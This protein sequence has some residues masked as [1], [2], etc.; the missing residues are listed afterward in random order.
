MENNWHKEYVVS[1]KCTHVPGNGRK[2]LRQYLNQCTKN[3]CLRLIILWQATSATTGIFPL[4]A[5]CGF[6]SIDWITFSNV[7]FR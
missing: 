6:F 1:I 5:Y 7:S 2:F 3:I 4:H